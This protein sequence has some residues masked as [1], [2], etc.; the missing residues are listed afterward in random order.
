MESGNE[1]LAHSYEQV[2]TSSTIVVPFDQSAAIVFAKLRCDLAISPPDAIQ[3]ACASVVGVDMFIT[4]DKRLSR[5][6][7][8]GVHFI[9]SLE[10]AAL[11][12]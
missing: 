8:P 1:K 2:I 7:V 9:H 10:M 5:D 3:L 6:V 4:N 11:L 12:L